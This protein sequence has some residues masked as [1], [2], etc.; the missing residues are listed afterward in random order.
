MKRNIALWNKA[1]HT[2]QAEEKRSK[3][4]KLFW[5]KPSNKRRRSKIVQSYWDS[6]S[7]NERRER[8]K[9]GFGA[10]N[11]TPQGRR[12]ISKRVQLEWDTMSLQAR[13]ARTAHWR[14]AAKN[15]SS[16]ELIIREFLRAQKIRFAAHK[17]IRTKFPD[18][19]LTGQKVVI[20]VDGE[21]WHKVL[22]RQSLDRKRDSVIHEDGYCTIS[23]TDKE[24]NKLGP[25]GAMAKA[26]K[27][28][29]TICRK[30]ISL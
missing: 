30:R 4:L 15:P 21:Y 29:C 6:L 19:V 12:Q 18:I 11:R 10:Y 28:G 20:Q 16:H 3:S 8:L 13:L 22:G 24:I 5:S 1:S 7:V 9:V 17:R 25:N 2:P 23:I 14:K 26:L 27:R